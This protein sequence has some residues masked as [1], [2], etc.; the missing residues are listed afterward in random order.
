M[1]S[2]R[3]LLAISVVYWHAGVF[4][5]FPLVAYGGAVLF[6]HIRLLHVTRPQ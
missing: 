5:G 6:R 1:G 4:L 2:L 3:F